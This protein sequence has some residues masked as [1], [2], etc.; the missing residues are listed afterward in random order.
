MAKVAFTAG[1][2]QR[3]TCP[4]DKQQA[5]I[6]DSTAPGL[7]LRA[8]PAGKPAFV[9][10]GVY[11]GKDIRITIGHP[12]AWSIAAAQAKARELQ[13]LIDEGKDPRAQKRQAIANDKA[14]KAEQIANAMTV[15]EAW[16]AYIEERKPFWG[17]RNFSDHIKLTQEGGEQRQRLPGTKTKPGPLAELMPLRLVD[18]TPERVEQWAAKE[19][20]VRPARV[21]LALRLLKAFLRWASTQPTMKGRADADAASTKKAREVAGRAKPKDDYLQ[22]EQLP[23][24]FENILNIPNPVISA[25]LQCLLLTG[26]RREEVAELKWED[27][28]FQWRS[29]RMKDKMEGTRAVPLTPYVGKLLIPLPRHNEWVFFS[30]RSESGHLEEP[31]IAHRDA[32]KIAGITLTLHGLRRSFASLCEWVE[33]PSGISAQIQG[34]APQGVREQN[35]IRRPLDLL[36][37]HHEKIEAWILAQGK[38]ELAAPAAS[39]EC[40]K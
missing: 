23:A 20:Q 16:S 33:I 26:A 10:Q 38:V 29:I 6:W 11:Q 14:E 35:Y 28:D 30:P 12:S 2:I 32:C 39:E 19:A 21:R 13:R 3:F 15:G 40:L 17:E 9:Y 24:W 7:G 34:H 4:D 36:R 31:S 8:T 25:Y 18:L 27:L 37:L 22:R 1:R 5:F